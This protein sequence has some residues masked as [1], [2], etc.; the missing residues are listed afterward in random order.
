M[1]RNRNFYVYHHRDQETG[2]VKNFRSADRLAKYL[3][4][5]FNENI[6]FDICSPGNREPVA[7]YTNT[8]DCLKLAPKLAKHLKRGQ[9]IWTKNWRTYSYQDKLL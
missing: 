1:T 5:T 3:V 9:V 8:D 2:E 7:Y 6:V 4:E